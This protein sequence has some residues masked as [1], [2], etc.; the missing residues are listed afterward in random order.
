MES[1]AIR[2]AQLSEEL[3]R[4]RALWVLVGTNAG[5]FSPEEAFK[6]CGTVDPAFATVRVYQ[7]VGTGNRHWDGPA[8]EQMPGYMR[9]FDRE[10]KEAKAKLVAVEAELRQINANRRG[11]HKGLKERL[12]Q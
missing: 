6:S 3:K 10:L 11:Y 2:D 5:T 8:E 1:Q 4:L 12:G 7:Q 9:W